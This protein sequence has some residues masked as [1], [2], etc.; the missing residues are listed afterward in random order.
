MRTQASRT[1][2]EQARHLES[3]LAPLARGRE[4]A[5]PG[6]QQALQRAAAGLDTGIESASPR[7][8]ATVRRLAEELAGGVETVTPRIHHGLQRVAPKAASLAVAPEPAE[9]RR[10]ACVVA[11]A[12]AVALSLAVAAWRAARASEAIAPGVEAQGGPRRNPEDDPES[13]GAR[14]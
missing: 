3:L 9:S 12:L 8:Q 2:T 4:W 6:V 10:K 14:S 1:R 13:A 11:A 7:I 5:T